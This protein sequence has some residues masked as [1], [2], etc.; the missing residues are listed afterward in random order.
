MSRTLYTSADSNPL[1]Y[2]ERPDNDQFWHV[3]ALR[4]A[5]KRPL[6]TT[7]FPF[8]PFL[9][10]SSTHP[11]QQNSHQ[12]STG[13]CSNST[14]VSE[15]LRVTPKKPVCSVEHPTSWTARRGTHKVRRLVTNNTHMSEYCECSNRTCCTA[16]A[17][18]QIKKDSQLDNTCVC[19]KNAKSGHP[20]QG[21]LLAGSLSDDAPFPAEA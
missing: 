20:T 18:E 19:I 6:F 4:S 13:G 5:E 15:R 7:H 11:T 3:K 17:N 2:V 10:P 1:A 9:R 16:N 14:S 12:I 21:C 8:H